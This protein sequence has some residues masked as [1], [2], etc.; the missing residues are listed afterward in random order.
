MHECTCIAMHTAYSSVYVYGDYPWYGLFKRLIGY[1][2]CYKITALFKIVK[3]NSYNYFRTANYSYTAIIF[4]ICLFYFISY[5]SSHR[6]A[7][8][9]ITTYTVSISNITDSYCI[10]LMMYFITYLR[11]CPC[12]SNIDSKFSLIGY[13]GLILWEQF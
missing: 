1:R 7:T 2:F 12:M 13:S 11:S 5:I 4:Q 6:Q 8:H 9:T 3:V 10:T